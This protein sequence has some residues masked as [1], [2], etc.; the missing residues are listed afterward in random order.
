MGTLLQ[1]VVNAWVNGASI[2]KTYELTP[3]PSLYDVDD[4]SALT[5]DA[6]FSTRGMGIFV[7]FILGHG[8]SDTYAKVTAYEG[9][10]VLTFA[11]S[12]NDNYQNANTDLPR[13]EGTK[14]EDCITVLSVDTTHQLVKLVR[15]GSNK[16]INMTDRTVFEYGY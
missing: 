11:S 12:A 15:V 7:S 8:H 9:L 13:I 3:Y 2:T 6:D 14:L 5:V 16:T 4:F 10:N 1:D